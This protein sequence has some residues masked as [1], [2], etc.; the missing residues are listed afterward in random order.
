MQKKAAAYSYLNLQE[1]N[2]HLPQ[3]CK[4]MYADKWLEDNIYSHD[5]IIEF[6]DHIFALIEQQINFDESVW[7]IIKH[8]H[9]VEAI[10]FTNT[11]L[12]SDA[13]TGS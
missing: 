6:S 8:H 11:H 12:T 13:Y 3:L 9:I 10:N 1:F 5:I 4:S 7:V 2:K